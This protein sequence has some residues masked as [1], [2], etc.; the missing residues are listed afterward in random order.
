FD[1]ARPSGENLRAM[2]SSVGQVATGA[3]TVASRD[4]VTN[5]VSI[6][7]GLWLGLADGVPVS[8][9]ESFDDVARAVIDRL[10][11]QPRAVVTLL[12]GEEAPPPLDVLL[13]ELRAR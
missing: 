2:E 9:G 10:L 7:K 5:G 12:T 6:R 8:A 11:A 3:V 4:V 13:A 1:A